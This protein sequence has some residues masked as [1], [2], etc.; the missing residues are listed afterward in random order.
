MVAVDI[1]DA[2]PQE[3]HHSENDNDV[4]SDERTGNEG[5]EELKVPSSQRPWHGRRF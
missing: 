4:K 1:E 2:T 3:A 5:G